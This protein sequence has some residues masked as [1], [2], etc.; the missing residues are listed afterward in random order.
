MKIIGIGKF[1]PIYVGITGQAAV[2]FLMLIKHGEVT[3]AFYHETLGTIDLVYGMGG[4]NGFGLAHVK[5]KHPD[6]LHSITDIIQQGA[7]IQKFDDRAYLE[8][9]DGRAIIR[10]DWDKNKKSWLVTAFKT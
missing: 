8:T 5:E 2:S 10:L 3:R 1:G 7:V 4:I 9:T 6:I